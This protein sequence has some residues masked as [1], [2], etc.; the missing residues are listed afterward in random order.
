ML[1]IEGLSKATAKSRSCATSRWSFAAA[2]SWPS[3]APTGLGKVDPAS[4]SRRS[5]HGRRGRGARGHEAR[6]GYFAQDH[7]G[8]DRPRGDRLDF[9]WAARP[10]E[11][12]A[13]VRGHLG[14]VLF[15]GDDVT[16]KAGMLSGGEAA[17]L[18]FGASW[19][20][21]QNVLVLDEPTNH[22]DIEAIH[23]LLE[24]LVAFEGTV[25]F[26]S[27]DRFF[28]SGLATRILEITPAGPRD[29]PGTYQ[30][31][32]ARCGDDHL[33]SDS[34]V[35]EGKKERKEEQAATRPP[36]AAGPH[37]LGRTEAAE[38][39]KERA[40]PA[41]RQG[42]GRRRA[43]RGAQASDTRP[44]REPGFTSEPPH[45]GRGPSRR[46]GQPRT[47]DRSPHQRMG[48]PRERACGARVRVRTR[49]RGTSAKGIRGEAPLG[50][51]R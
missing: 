8:A 22:L 20:R 23:A 9:L 31:Y 42:P 6:V 3:L 26:V 41:P 19:P 2:K 21:G 33:D 44:V 17:R 28:V 43:G 36:P 46:R 12:T 30:E 15:S 35:P 50:K 48:S 45:R 11:S 29:F 5:C 32:L 49:S 4:R 39:P 18:I 7:Q 37:R 38:Q 24:A 1:T 47:E 51:P 27:H 14:R 25:I 40:A 13:F 10:Q 16:K 34:V